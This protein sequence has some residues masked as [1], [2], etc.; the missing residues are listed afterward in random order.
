MI[1]NL[2]QKAKDLAFNNTNSGMEATNVQEALDELNNK[3][4]NLSIMSLYVN[5]TLT[6]TSST[7]S[8][9]SSRKFSDYDMLIIT[10][11][12]SA[13][14]I[15]VT[16]AIPRSVFA[17]GKTFYLDCQTN[18]GQTFN[19]ISVKYSSDTSITASLTTS[20][21]VCNILNIYGIKVA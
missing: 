16:L 3:S 21:T 4:C 7:Y 14:D 13:T 20:T 11:G 18:N 2:I 17:Q 19:Q 15:R 10:L 12:A 8:T 6:T 5:Q 1:F 9:Y